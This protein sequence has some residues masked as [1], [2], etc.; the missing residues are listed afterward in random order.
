LQEPE[1]LEDISGDSILSDAQGQPEKM[2]TLKQDSR[3]EGDLLSRRFWALHENPLQY[4]GKLGS[5]GPAPE[6]QELV[7]ISSPNPYLCPGISEQGYK[8]FYDN[9]SN[10][11]T[12]LSNVWKMS[13]EQRAFEEQLVSLSQIPEYWHQWG[14]LL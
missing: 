3:E 9:D 4:P 14:R 11:Y 8:D 7:L 2:L 6:T 12:G 13:P 5:M 1:L 10:A